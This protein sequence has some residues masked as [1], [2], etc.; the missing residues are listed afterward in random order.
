MFDSVN[1][2]NISVHEDNPELRLNANR[3]NFK[4]LTSVQHKYAFSFK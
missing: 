2:Y 4:H 1:R 3:S